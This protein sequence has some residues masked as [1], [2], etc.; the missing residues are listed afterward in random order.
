MATRGLRATLAHA[1]GR[2]YFPHQLS[3]LI[4]N[5][6]RRVLITPGELADRIPWTETRRVLEVGPGSGYFSVALARRA[7]A[8][9][10]ELFDL[11][12]EMLAKARRKLEAA[13][14]R[15]VGYTQGDASAL[16]YGASTFDVAVL[17]AVLGEVPDKS[18]CLEL[19]LQVLS[20]DGVLVV[21]EHVPDPDRI[22]PPELRALAETAG[23]AFD[24]SYGP[25]WNHTAIFRRRLDSS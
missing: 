17:V 12:R 7:R 18:S 15:N 24:R 3:F 5:P 4:D 19:L 9:R 2:G 21:H 25:S 16:P 22:A 6:I 13:G 11:Q 14:H 20:P 10:L 1:W 8:G 23:F